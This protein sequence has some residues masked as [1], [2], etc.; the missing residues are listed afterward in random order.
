MADFDPAI[1]L[2]LGLQPW[3]NHIA[4]FSPGLDDIAARRQR[5]LDNGHDVMEID[6][7]WCHSVYAMDPNRVL[8]E[9]C[10]DTAPYT[11]QDRTDALRVV[12]ASKDDLV[13]EEQREPIFHRAA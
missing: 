3:V 1:S 7:G 12:S 13:F 10:T 8:V 11:A 9:F 6:H 2:G 5:W 4:F